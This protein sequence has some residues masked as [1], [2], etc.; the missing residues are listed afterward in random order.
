MKILL[1]HNY[2]QQPG[3]EDTSFALE[4]ELLEAHGHQTVRYTLHNDAIHRMSSLNT[5]SKT[6]WNRKSYNDVRKLIKRERPEV[7]HCTNTFPLISPAVYYAAKELGVAVVQSLRNYRLLC[8]SAQLM[9]DGRVCESCLGKRLAWPGVLHGCYRGSR[10]GTAVVAGML[11]WHR[12]RRTYTDV[13]D[14]Y[15]ALT[16]FSRDKFIEGGLPAEKIAVKPNFLDPDPGAGSGDGNYV[17][18]VGRLSPEKG[19]DTLLSAWEQLKGDFTLK[20]VGDGPLASDVQQAAHEDS[21]IQWLGHQRSGAV[22]DIVGRAAALVLPSVWYEG[23]PRTIVEAFSRG[24]PVVA[25]NLGSMTEIIDHGANGLHVPPGDAAELAAAVDRIMGNAQLRQRMREAAR[26][27]FLANY[28][29]DRNY[30]MLM[31]I[32]DAALSGEQRELSPTLAV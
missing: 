28:T 3:G 12:W 7:M 9:R 10:L 19:I 13:V 30:E 4:A 16:E 6:L 26:G 15:Y 22:V 25:S 29:A 17:V 32:Y 11:A 27:D 18:F 5:A 1:C 21:R 20:I 14:R 8:P 23:F 2:Y 24:T 31:E